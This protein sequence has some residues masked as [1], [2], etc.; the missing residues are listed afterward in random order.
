MAE[1]TRPEGIQE[2]QLYALEM[3]ETY[4]GIIAGA[5]HANA[6]GTKPAPAKSVPAATP[7]AA[8]PAEPT[9]DDVRA[10]LK[11]YADNFGR[12]AAI[13]LLK[14]AGY[15]NAGTVPAEKRAEFIKACQ[16]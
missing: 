4:L 5:T 10:V 9:A 6:G 1:E 8:A 3:I 2:R 16:A 14:D 13:K 7:A 12:E 15:K 11:D